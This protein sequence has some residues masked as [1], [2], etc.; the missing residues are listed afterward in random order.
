MLRQTAE[1]TELD[2]MS[3][4]AIRAAEDIMGQL[5]GKGCEASPAPHPHMRC[6]VYRPV[7]DDRTG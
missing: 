2:E 6:S 7:G 1:T 3:P 4:E 5:R